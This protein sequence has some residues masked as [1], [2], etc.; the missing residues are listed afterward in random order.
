MGPEA[1]RKAAIRQK[2][3]LKRAFTL[4]FFARQLA[5]AAHGLCL[6]TGFL[7]RR[8]FKMLLELHFAKNPLALKFFLQGTKCLFDVIVANT[9]LHVVVTTFLG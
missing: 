7:D 1:C 6:F 8:F 2:D 9:Y 4:R 5:G 3:S